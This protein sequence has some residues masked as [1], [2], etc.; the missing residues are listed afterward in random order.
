[1]DTSPPR[2][3]VARLGEA[4]GEEHEEIAAGAQHAGEEDGEAILP[5]LPRHRTGPSQ[6]HGQEGDTGATI[7][8][9]RYG[10]GLMCDTPT[11]STRE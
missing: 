5:P 11:L 4:E 8:V 6:H 1:M 3:H 7:M 9:Q 10:S 2:H